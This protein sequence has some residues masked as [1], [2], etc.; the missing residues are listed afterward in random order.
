[1]CMEELLFLKNTDNKN[2]AHFICKPFANST[3]TRSAPP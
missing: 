3:A 2:S 1:M